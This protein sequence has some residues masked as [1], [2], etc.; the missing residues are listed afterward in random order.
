MRIAQSDERAFTLL[1]EQYSATIY[2]HVLTYLKNASRAEEIT[3]DIFMSVWRH[4]TELPSISNFPGYLYVITRNR[5]NS[6]F[7]ERLLKYEEVEKDELENNWLNP[8][9]E[10]ELRQLSDT[11][12]KGIQSMPPRRKQVFSMSRFEGKSYDTIAAELD[13]SKSA[14]NKHIIEALLFLRTHLRNQ[15][16]PLIIMI[17]TIIN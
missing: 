13:I 14:V 6:A 9:G 7:R 10:L 5:T 4:R 2:S 17:L 1:V 16:G 11:L 12:M 8:A 3:Q 15:M